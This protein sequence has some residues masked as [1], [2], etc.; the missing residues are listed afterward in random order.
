MRGLKLV[1]VTAAAVRAASPLAA[2]QSRPPSPTFTVNTT[3]DA[4]DADLA[5]CACA[6]SGGLCS[7]R[8]AIM[9]ADYTTGATII[10]PARAS[11]Y[12]LTIPSPGPS[13]DPA[14]GDLDIK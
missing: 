13:S 4:V 3:V 6:T 10:V 5:D 14:T 9:Q 8:A 12:M 11:P 7:L 1:L 2:A